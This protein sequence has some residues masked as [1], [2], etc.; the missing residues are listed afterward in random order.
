MLFLFVLMLKVMFSLVVIFLRLNRVF[1]V[2][3][4]ILVIVLVVSLVLRFIGLYFLLLL[5]IVVMIIFIFL[6]VL[7]VKWMKVL[8]LGVF[9][10]R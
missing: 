6:F 1:I 7:L 8:V 9:I 10:G 5:L 3:L 4:E 2:G